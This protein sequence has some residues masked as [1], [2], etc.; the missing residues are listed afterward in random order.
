MAHFVEH[1]RIDSSNTPK[2]PQNLKDAL[3]GEK[4]L[5]VWLEGAARISKSGLPLSVEGDEAP[6]A[7]Q[8]DKSLYLGVEVRLPPEKG[9]CN[10]SYPLK[11]EVLDYS[12]CKGNATCKENAVNTVL[13]SA[14]AA[15]Q[16]SPIS[17]NPM[18]DEPLGPGEVSLQRA[19][20]PSLVLG[21]PFYELS[22]YSIH[23][24]T[25]SSD[26]PM[27]D[28]YEKTSYMGTGGRGIAAD[29]GPLL[30]FMYVEHV[31]TCTPNKNGIYS[32]PEDAQVK[33][34]DLAI[35]NALLGGIKNACTTLRGK[36]KGSVCVMQ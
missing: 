34:Y 33:E 11:G 1:G 24:Y 32:E 27:G 19:Y 8:T 9:G 25:A 35:Q 30:L 28:A 14:S 18:L 5:E 22:T 16:A 20:Q 12:I 23:T 21:R 6:L 4:I 10:V 2:F 26:H 15:L 29:S 31:L 13:Q 17:S 7:I 3:A 36:M